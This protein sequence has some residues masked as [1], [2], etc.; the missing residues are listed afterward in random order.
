MLY[1][2]M[3]TSDIFNT[4]HVATRCNRVAKSRRHVAPNNV[5]IVWPGH[6]NVGPTKFGHDVMICCDRSARAFKRRFSL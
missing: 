3:R 6:V 4:Q 1:P 2:G 5:A